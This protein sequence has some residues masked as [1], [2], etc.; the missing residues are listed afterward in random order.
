ML[1]K[2]KKLWT[3]IMS[4]RNKVGIN[5][6]VFATLLSYQATVNALVQDGENPN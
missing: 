1:R 6:L 2:N 3:K 5:Y 4:G